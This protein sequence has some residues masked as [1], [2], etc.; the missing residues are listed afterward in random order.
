MEQILYPLLTQA[1]TCDGQLIDYVINW[2]NGNLS[3]IVMFVTSS[4]KASGTW[5]FLATRGR[6]GHNMVER[7]IFYL[8]SNNDYLN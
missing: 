7:L 4:K 3:N 6:P 8:I 5:R 1:A 2:M